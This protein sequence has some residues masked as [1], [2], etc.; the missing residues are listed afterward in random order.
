MKTLNTGDTGY[1]SGYSCYTL[2]NMNFT[3]NW[4][5]LFG[6]TTPSEY[7]NNLI[8]ESSTL[9]EKLKTFKPKS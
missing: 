5:T 3:F 8:T 7:Y 2:N 1:I 4:G 6:N 9:E